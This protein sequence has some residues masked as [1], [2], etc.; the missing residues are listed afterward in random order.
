MPLTTRFDPHEWSRVY[1]DADGP[2][3][4][5]VFRRSAA[6]AEAACADVMQAG[7][8]WLDFGSGTGQMTNAL[9]SRGAQVASVDHDLSM[10]R[11]AGDGLAARVEAL[12][13]A[14]ACMNGVVAVSLF[15]CLEDSTAAFHEAWR[16]LLPG[17]RLVCTFTNAASLLLS[18]NSLVAGSATSR[19]RLY[20]ASM[21]RAEL[22]T[23]GFR[24]DHIRWYNTVLHVGRRL[25]PTAGLARWLDDRGVE[26]LARN[27]L[28]VAKKP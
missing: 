16:V 4:H 17:G 10:L 21:V 9:Q 22:E 27:F 1:D 8:R 5:H 2:A 3:Q 14:N 18:I 26:R 12:P 20:R 15:G 7:D 19:F 13:F 24:I 6:V 23:I 11:F 25:V 28:V